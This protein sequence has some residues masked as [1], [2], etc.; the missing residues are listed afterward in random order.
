MNMLT[1][2]QISSV[3]QFSTLDIIV[4]LG[5][6]IAV[7]V[8][9]VGT[10]RKAGDS[11]K[12]YFLAG[13]S[14]K[15][16]LIGISLI[17]ANISTE[18]F[19]GMS[20]SASMCTGLA[21]A[22]YEWIA[23]VTLIAVAF[24]F[25]PMFLRSGIYTIP[26]FLEYRYNKLSRSLLSFFMM[27][28]LVGVSTAAVIS[29]GALTLV[30]LLQGVEIPLFG[31][32]IPITMVNA[33]W[34]MGVL[35][36][37]YVFTGG[38]KACAWTDLLQGTALIIGGAIVM[39]YAF[40]EFDKMPVEQVNTTPVYS[41]PEAYQQEHS[42]DMLAGIQQD[43]HVWEKFEKANADKLHM[44][45]PLADPNIVW[46]TLLLGIWIP[47]LY[48]WGLNQYIMQRT[49]GSQ[50]LAEGQKGLIFAAGLKLLI[51]F[52][53]VFPGIL[54]FNMYHDQMVSEAKIDAQVNRDTLQ[55]FERIS[56]GQLSAE[57]VSA[58]RAKTLFAF[59]RDY[60]VL[61]ETHSREIVLHNMG[62]LGKAS[63]T[64]DGMIAVE[65]EKL[66]DQAGAADK[67][68]IAA[69]K[70]DGF[71]HSQ[72]AL[73]AVNGNLL[74]EV[75]KPTLTESLGS[76]VG[77]KSSI[78]TP[79]SKELVGYKYDSAFPLLLRNLPFASGIR[80]FVLAAL[81]GAVVS[82]LAA[83]LN[84]A[85]TIFTMDIYKEYMHKTASE[86]TMVK[87]GRYSVLIFT[88]IACLLAPVLSDPRFGGLFKYI[89]EFQGYVS[90]GVLAV[91][92][93]GII[94]PR[95]PGFAGALALLLSPC[96]YGAMKIVPYPFFSEMNFLNQMGVTFGILL[97]F[98]A[99]LTLLFPRKEKLTLEIK[100]DMDLRS[101]RSAMVAGVVVLVAT[102]G[103][104]IYYW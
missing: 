47:N 80:G 4:L 64:L 31:Y 81:L 6:V 99:L 97:A 8:I 96:I 52:I 66:L 23:A 18:Q 73:T 71:L 91:F 63:E 30:T 26:E 68:L 45:R 70:T 86:K 41:R 11:S 79:V 49:L 36:A 12:D 58:G 55:L 5:F 14:L 83:M 40:A 94:A 84:A 1:L 44:L 102:A 7:I 60:A 98:L 76:F 72:L 28:I 56:T 42:V 92:L 3:F 43:T 77:R 54:A 57:D 89:Q 34:V 46:T 37:I 93:F 22:S 62:I 33:S 38:L 19:I 21:I 29:M 48:Y 100:T 90:P 82:S 15:W 35:A 67:T 27:M 95:V 17:S 53:V 39:V 104:Y 88:I 74:A 61:H 103:L 32:S 13:R 20:G 59:N 25:L 101:S 85:S 87:V 24:I 9:G 78:E 51:P 75:P 10:S 50:S 69:L 65:K 2:A 16:W